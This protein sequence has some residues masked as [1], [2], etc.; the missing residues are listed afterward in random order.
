MAKP[1]KPSRPIYNR[2]W[3]CKSYGGHVVVERLG[4]PV[5]MVDD[6]KTDA[7]FECTHAA[8]TSLAFGRKKCT[9]RGVGQCGRTTG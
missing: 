3:P 1:N 2:R 9:A 8:S 5:F 7:T 6:Q 4:R